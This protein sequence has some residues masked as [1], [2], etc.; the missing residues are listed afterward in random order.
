MDTSM[1]SGSHV[2]G[3]KLFC[4]RLYQ[5]PCPSGFAWGNACLHLLAG[6][7]RVREMVG[8][9][10]RMF[11]KESLIPGLGR[12]EGMGPLFPTGEGMI[13]GERLTC[14]SALDWRSAGY[15]RTHP[16]RGPAP[17]V[18]LHDKQPVLNCLCQLLHLNS[19]S[20]GSVERSSSSV[21]LESP[22]SDVVVHSATSGTLVTSITASLLDF[23]NEGYSSSFSI[24]HLWR[25]L[26]TIQF[27]LLSSEKQ[28]SQS[29]YLWTSLYLR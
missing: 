19:A 15:S 22:A 25:T 4:W 26:N 9:G 1:D 21:S 6:L 12:G 27:T 23:F 28:L 18:H 3:L 7:G 17:V 5:L 24:E 10:R 2:D 13:L 20:E 11:A 29:N 16:M 8:V 14:S